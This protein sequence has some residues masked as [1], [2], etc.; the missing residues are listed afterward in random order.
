MNA[1]IDVET[2][3]TN[4]AHKKNTEDLTTHEKGASEK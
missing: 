3:Y 4:C 1:I 2:K